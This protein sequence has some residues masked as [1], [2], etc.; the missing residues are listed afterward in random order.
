MVIG[1]SNYYD[2][3]CNTFFL[4][5][6]KVRPAD[7]VQM[8][9][10]TI[11]P[12]AWTRQMQTRPNQPWAQCSVFIPQRA[13][14]VLLPSPQCPFMPRLVY[15][16]ITKLVAHHRS[17][18]YTMPHQ[19]SSSAQAQQPQGPMRQLTQKTVL[20]S[21]QTS[22]AALHLYAE[23]HCQASLSGFSLHNQPPRSL[24]LCFIGGQSSR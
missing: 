18:L 13:F 4:P 8:K 20:I 22:S 14:R 21:A 15:I 19:A 23:P 16:S 17:Y 10:A 11:L 12:L 2:Y 24:G 3:S 5:R 7:K 6:G 1:C 9:A